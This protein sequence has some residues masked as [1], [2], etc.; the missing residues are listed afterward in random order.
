ML[1]VAFGCGK[2][3][4][5]PGPPPPAS[6]PFDG[7]WIGA[8]S[9]NSNG[10]GILKFAITQSSIGVHGTFEGLFT[11]SALNS[12]GSMSAFFTGSPTHIAMAMTCDGGGAGGFDVTLEN[13][14]ITGTYVAG[15]CGGLTIGTLTL[16]PQVSASTR[17]TR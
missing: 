6:K 16:V 9:D 3:P 11:N 4:T 10:N 13:L 14:R 8:V 5:E 1:I 17:A 12:S 15:T 2:S 7:P